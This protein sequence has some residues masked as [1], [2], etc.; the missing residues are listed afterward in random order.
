M[1]EKIK[2]ALSKLS[3]RTGL[4]LLVICLLF[5]GV[6]ISLFAIPL[7]GEIKALLITISFALAK[8]FQYSAIAILGVKGVMRIKAWIRKMKVNNKHNNK[9]LKQ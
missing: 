8:I 3:F 9:T 1:W 4:I 2:T 7:E 5:H 6:A